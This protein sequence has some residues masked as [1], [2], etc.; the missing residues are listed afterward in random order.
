MQG[1]A[2]ARLN[3]LALVFLPL[4][5]AAVCPEVLSGSFVMQ[6]DKL[7]V[8]IWNDHV[9]RTRAVVSSPCSTITSL[10]NLDRRYSRKIVF[11][12]TSMA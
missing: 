2:V 1:Q 3:A 8:Y 4:G 11:S 5:F 10:Y 12:T 6:A 9:Y 7:I